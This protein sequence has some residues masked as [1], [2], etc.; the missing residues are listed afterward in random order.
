VFGSTGFIGRYMIYELAKRG[1]QVIIPWRKDEMRIRETQTMGDTG[2]LVN[3]RFHNEKY[4]TIED[5]CS[6]SNIV[7]NATGRYFDKYGDTMEKCNITFAE[8]VARVFLY[9]NFK[10]MC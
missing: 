9:L 4:I 1:Y 6:R 10:G 5:I 8:D 2:Q 7:V 3:M